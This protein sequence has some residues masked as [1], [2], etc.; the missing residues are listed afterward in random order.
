MSSLATYIVNTKAALLSAL[1]SASPLRI[2]L[3]ATIPLDTSITIPD[4]HTIVFG[5]H[6][7][8]RRGTSATIVYYGG[9]EADHRQIF[10]GYLPGNITGTFKGI[11]AKPVWWGA[12]ATPTAPASNSTVR[13]DVAIN[14]AIK[15]KVAYHGHVVQ[16]D[17]GYYAIGDSIDLST[18]DSLLRGQGPNRTFLY[19]VSGWNPTW[20]YDTLWDGT[21]TAGRSHSAV[22]WVGGNTPDND[23]SYNTGVCDLTINAA[24]ASWAN[25]D[26]KNPTTGVPT[27][28]SRPLKRVSGISTYGWI[29]E[30]T[31]V[32]NINITNFTGYGIGG[33]SGTKPGTAQAFRDTNGLNIRN[34]WITSGYASDCLPVAFGNHS[35]VCSI[36]SGTIDMKTDGARNYVRV[37]IWSQ[38]NHTK[39]EDVHFESVRFGVLISG[40]NSQNESVEV[41]NVDLLWGADYNMN[42]ANTTIPTGGELSTAQKGI[43]NYTK[44]SCVVLVVGQ[45]K[46]TSPFVS[47]AAT[48]AT[49]GE[50]SSGWSY[51]NY[52]M[53][54]NLRNIMG[55]NVK[56]VIRDYAMGVHVPCWDVNQSR[57]HSGGITSY[58]RSNVFKPATSTTYWETGE[59]TGTFPAGKTYMTL[60]P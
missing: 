21:N 38:G 10:F 27:L 26:E 25:M 49:E 6:G 22:V 44:W 19:T 54:V 33:C 55:E 45:T 1:A 59:P 11:P 52:H 14:C 23:Y 40:S 9:L 35:R 2:T 53:R 46:E 58:Q 56:Y 24:Y 20:Y 28:A 4:R 36:K 42:P 15:A 8:L 60:V 7:F 17:A 34:F 57:Q 29:Q 37:G 51:T 30:Q 41:N 18:T 50:H 39:I 48:D 31:I 5:P 12:Y 16:L 32:E 3:G 47:I 13:D 43:V